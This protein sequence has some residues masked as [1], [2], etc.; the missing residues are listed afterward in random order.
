MK[1]IVDENI[2][3]GE[4]AFSNFGS[5]ELIHGRKINSSILKEAEILIVRSITNVNEDLLKETKIKFVGT[6]TIGTD[7]IDKE[8]LKSKKIA[9]ADAAGC[10]SHA[11]KEYVFT[12]LLNIAEEKNLSLKNLTIGIAGIGNIGSKIVPLAKILG[13]E[14]LKNDPPLQRKTGSKDFV[15]LEKILNADI[16][17]LHVP[18][19]LKGKDK[20]F[21]LFDDKNLRRLKD[22]AVLINASRGPVVDGN[23]LN[24]L[25]D[26]KNLTVV[27]DVWENEPKI[28][29]DLLKKV[30]FA[31][32]H[33]AG[34]T[35]E[36]KVNGTVMIY[37]SLC[38]FLNI[39]PEWKP[40]LPKVEKPLIK[41]NKKK[42]LESTL[43]EIFNEI[44]S[45][46]NDN[47]NMKNIIL[48]KPEER[49][50]FF[51]QLRKSY[52]LRRE[53]NNYTIF[54]DEPDP[55]LINIL[56]EFGFKVAF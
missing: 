6:A 28:N 13:M 54:P 3:F 53:F 29:I 17:T 40:I 47:K 37:N 38:E 16:I 11:V 9:F 39:L 35:L 2:A 41:I 55:E 18:L 1:I 56:N 26:K 14:V 5:V 20:T 34:Y 19:N 43:K 12:A 52:D 27:L 31:S 10:N 51:D 50:N 48:L 30:K 8:Y 23:A 42:S 24:N 4:E 25:I 7:H 22:G 21:H 36:G 45:I 33:I 46:E 49:G 32:P 15:E 44:Y